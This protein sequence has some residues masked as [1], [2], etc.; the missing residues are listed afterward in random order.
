[1]P[2]GPSGD[3]AGNA[4]EPAAE[5]ALTVEA[6][7][8]TGEDEEGGLEGVLGVLLVTQDAA[9]QAEH[10]RSVALYEGG[11]GGLLTAVDESLQQVRIGGV[12]PGQGGEPAAEAG[13]GQAEQ[14]H[15]LPFVQVGPL[16][17]NCAEVVG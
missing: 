6:G 11:E 8:F 15:G 10:E 1:L 13:E 16:Y 3:A 2:C 4:E 17:C 5:G 14:S 9:A 12:R 7:G